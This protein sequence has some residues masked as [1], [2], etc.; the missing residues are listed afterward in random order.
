MLSVIKNATDS[1]TAAPIPIRFLSFPSPI[2]VPDPNHF[3][4]HP[5][6]PDHLNPLSF[7][8]AFNR[9]VY[10]PGCAMSP[11]LPVS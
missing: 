2:S 10:Y 5:F 11:K 9:F 7:S 1:L 6:Q 8:D 4:D 3:S